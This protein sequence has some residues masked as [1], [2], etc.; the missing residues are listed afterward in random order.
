MTKKSCANCGYYI[1]GYWCYHDA[2]FQCQEKE[3]N[4]WK[5]KEDV[6]DEMHERFRDVSK[7]DISKILE[8][9]NEGYMCLELYRNNRC[10]F[11]EALMMIVSEQK[12][13]YDRLCELMD[14]A[15]KK[16]KG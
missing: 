7:Q 6:L 4:L 5:S 14:E 2:E 9:N 1:P 10:S 3:Y 8:Y 11:E 16:R 12:K 13:Q 15:M